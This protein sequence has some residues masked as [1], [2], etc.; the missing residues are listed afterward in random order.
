[1]EIL[2]GC[3][4]ELSDFLDPLDQP[5]CLS[6]RRSSSCLTPCRASPEEDA[7]QGGASSSSILPAPPSDLS[8]S[9]VGDYIPCCW[10][11]AVALEEL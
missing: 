5:K 8:T 1:M 2:G 9:Q 6:L 11:V 3:T 10:V 4:E 7:L